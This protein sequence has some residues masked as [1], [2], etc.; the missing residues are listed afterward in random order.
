MR[1]HSIEEIQKTTRRLSKNETKV[2][3]GGYFKD[4]RD[5]NSGMPTLMASGS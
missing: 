5:R 3:T 2:I 4:I 1:K